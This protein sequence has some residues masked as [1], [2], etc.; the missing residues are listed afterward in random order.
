MATH[1]VPGANPAN[2]DTLRAG[3]WAE[4]ADGSLIY[5]KGTEGD[6]V[7]YE[8]FD[9]AHTP[10]VVYTDAMPMAGFKSQFSFGGKGTS[11]EKWVWHDK[12]PFDWKRVM[13]TGARPGA[14]FTSAEDA[15]S[16]A[17]RVAASLKLRAKKVFSET[18]AHRT[19]EE[20]KASASASIWDRI[21]RAVRTLLD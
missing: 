1:D 19:D 11:K 7:V 4:H 13:R 2:R 5:V 15:M 12:T 20:V 21:D 16:A 14:G 3:C 17:E 10:P 8:L 18:F 9:M 6:T